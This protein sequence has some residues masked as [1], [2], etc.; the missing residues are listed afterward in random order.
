ME[1]FIQDFPAPEDAFDE[2]DFCQAAVRAKPQSELWA[3]SLVLAGFVEFGVTNLQKFGLLSSRGAFA[4]AAGYWTMGEVKSAKNVLERYQSYAGDKAFRCLKQFINKKKITAANIS[5][6]L[7]L[8][9]AAQDFKTKP[10]YQLGQFSVFNVATQLAENALSTKLED[11]FEF[12]LKE[13]FADKV[14]LIVS[15]TPQWIVPRGL[16]KID[17]PKVLWAHDSDFMLAKNYAYYQSFNCI[18][19]SMSQEHFEMRKSLDVFCMANNF[20]DSLQTPWQGQLKSG[21]KPVGKIDVFFSGAA[22]SS[23]MLDR[24]HLIKTLSKISEKNRIVIV[25]GH[26]NVDAYHKLSSSSSYVILMNRYLGCPSPRWRDALV[27]GSKLIYPEGSVYGAFEGLG[28]S[29]EPNSGDIDL[30]KRKETRSSKNLQEQS[31]L[32][33]EPLRLPAETLYERFLKTCCISVCLASRKIEKGWAIE[34]SWEPCWPMPSMDLHL[35]GYENICEKIDALQSFVRAQKREISASM[36]NQLAMMDINKA[37]F[38]NDDHEEQRAYINALRILEEGLQFH[39]TS[40]L[41]NFNFVHGCFYFS[42]LENKTKI[43]LLNKLLKDFDALDFDVEGSVWGIG[44]AGTNLEEFFS[45]FEINQKEMMYFVSRNNEKERVLYKSKIKQM[46]L[47]AAHLMI[48]ELHFSSEEGSVAKKHAKQAVKANPKSW[49]AHLFL[50]KIL[51]KEIDSLGRSKKTNKKTKRESVK[52]AQRYE[53]L[54]S[55]ALENPQVLLSHISQL[56]EACILGK[57]TEHLNLILKEWFMLRSVIYY[58]NEPVLPPFSDAD[59]N[60]MLTR[61]SPYISIELHNKIK[62]WNVSLSSSLDAKIANDER[63]L[64]LYA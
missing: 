43:L 14:D 56:I 18:N 37:V 28:V 38:N 29:F 53:A 61:V 10:R 44:M 32:L 59:K 45:A 62:N 64:N 4:L 49:F 42:K 54:S 7:P 33:L 24:A 13:S 15:Q 47:C 1:D 55:A 5:L 16:G 35:F 21:S 12:S 30:T 22:L 50:A 40:L 19:V 2:G 58:P 20:A 31:N 3:A 60:E 48:G 57:K 36:F 25:D 26:L 34:S 27:G 8:T 51:K 11:E 46:L 6:T 39:P 17:V 41:L 9:S 23:P 63:L 52:Q